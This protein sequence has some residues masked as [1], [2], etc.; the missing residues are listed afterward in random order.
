MGCKVR[1][2]GFFVSDEVRKF[3]LGQ[4]SNPSNMKIMLSIKKPILDFIRM[5]NEAN[6]Y[7]HLY[8]GPFIYFPHNGNI[9]NGIEI[10]FSFYDIEGLNIN[11]IYTRDPQMPE[12]NLSDQICSIEIVKSE[13]HRPIKNIYTKSLVDFLENCDAES[14]DQLKTRLIYKIV[15]MN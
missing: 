5:S 8:N 15:Q 6:I 1:E 11:M 4:S 9:N 10:C 2:E 13:K 7:Y 3:I 12:Q 14:D